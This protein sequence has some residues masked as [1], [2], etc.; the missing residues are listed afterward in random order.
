MMKSVITS[1]IGKCVPLLIAATTLATSQGAL[2]AGDWN[3]G[4]GTGFSSF[5]LDGE[6]GFGTGTAN[7]GV[8]VDGDLSNS[9]TSDLI[10]SAFGLAGFAQK[11]QLKIVA[12]VKTV[13]LS[14]KDSGYKV[15][16]DNSGAELYL[17]YNFATTGTHHWGGIIGVRYTEHDWTFTDRTTDEKFKPDDNWTDVIVGVSHMMPLSDEWSWSTRADYGFGGSEGTFFATTAINWKP[18]EHWV[19]SVNASYLDTEANKKSDVDK[20]NGYYY[21]ADQT[22]FGIGVAV[23]W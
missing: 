1:R 22:A 6:V 17:D 9:D 14:D 20:P 18:L 8:I 10:S 19:F 15:D 2:A 4:I 23:V 21:N 5:S 7:N 3:Y 13:T 12:S 11:D 16:W